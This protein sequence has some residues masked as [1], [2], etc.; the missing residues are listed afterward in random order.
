MRFKKHV[1]KFFYRQCRLVYKYYFWKL[2]CFSSRCLVYMVRPRNKFV[3][4]TEYW[5]FPIFVKSFNSLVPLKCFYNI[6]FFW[7]LFIE[8]IAYYLILY[9]WGQFSIKLKG[10]W[11]TFIYF[12]R[13]LSYVH[14]RV[15]GG[16]LEISRVE[17]EVNESFSF[18]RHLK[19]PRRKRRFVRAR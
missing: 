19:Y 3:V 10:K 18:I 6:S 7:N 9:R 2:P 4:F 17:L 5:I 8:I 14:R 12:Y 13:Y 11:R 1:R 15:S 16:F